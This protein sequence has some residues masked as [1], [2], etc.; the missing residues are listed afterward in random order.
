MTRYA[1]V[2][3]D[4]FDTLVRLDR[5]RLPAARIGGREVRSSVPKLHGIARSVLPGVGLEVFYDAFLWSYQEADRL[6]AENHREVSAR[7]RLALFY[8][9]VGVDPAGI[10]VLGDRATSW[11]PTWPAS[12]TPPSPCPDRRSS[13]T[14]WEAG[15][16][17]A[18]SRTSTTRRPSSASSRKAGSSADSRRWSSRTTVGWRKPHPDI[19]ERAL[20]DM[21]VRAADCLF[22]GDRPD[23]DVAGAKG[24]GMAVAWLNP[25]RDAPA[26]GAPGPGPRPRRPGR[27]PAGTGPGLTGSL[28]P[29]PAFR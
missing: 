29:G 1:A 25:G 28:T 14:G 9:R 5:G 3:F 2:L 22:V 7:E 19:F 6:R 18:S 15:S 8:R 23:I 20:A 26:A 13:W 11:P 21:G 16:A 12:R 27:P 10:C 17:W 24:V 4:M